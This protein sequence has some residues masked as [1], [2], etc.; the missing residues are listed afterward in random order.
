MIEGASVL[1]VQR[2]HELLEQGWMVPGDKFFGLLMSRRLSGLT[3][4]NYDAFLVFKVIVGTDIP[5]GDVNRL[6]SRTNRASHV[7]NCSLAERQ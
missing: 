4:D 5:L 1:V 7:R 6:F 2:N 3:G